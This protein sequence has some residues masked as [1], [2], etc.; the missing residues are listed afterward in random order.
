MGWTGSKAM[1]VADSGGLS[2][3]RWGASSRRWC[4]APCGAACC[5]CTCATRAPLQP[6]PQQQ[7]SGL[8]GAPACGLELRSTHSGLLA[9][10]RGHIQLDTC[11]K[12]QQLPLLLARV[13]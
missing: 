8:P 13:C 2:L 5:R 4:C 12:L 7:P 9:V 6:P 11:I 10:V 1:A 3:Q